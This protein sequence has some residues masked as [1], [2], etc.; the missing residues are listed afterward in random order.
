MKDFIKG[1]FSEEAIIGGL[2][3]FALVYIATALASAL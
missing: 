2:V 1:F 3:L